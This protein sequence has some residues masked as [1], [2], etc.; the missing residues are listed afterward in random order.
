MSWRD[1]VKN[2]LEKLKVIPLLALAGSLW[3]IG[4]TGHKW[5]RR[6]L[7]PGVLAGFYLYKTHDLIG[8]AFTYLFGMIFSIGYGIPSDYPPENP[9]K[10][11]TIAIFWNKFIKDL[12]AVRFLTRLT[13]ATAYSTIMI[14]FVL[15][16]VKTPWDMLGLAVTVPLIVDL[17]PG[18]IEEV[19][20]GMAV[21]YWFTRGLI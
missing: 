18:A 13:V 19:L 5:T 16:G 3:K 10:G 21:M 20:V 6:F 17:E 9:D 14:P 8:T 7:L 1:N 11:S 12:R 15:H 4:G 2:Y